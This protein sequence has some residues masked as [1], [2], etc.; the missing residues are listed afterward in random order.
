MKHISV[1][2]AALLLTATVY[3][4]PTR[5][6]IGKA[7][8]QNIITVEAVATGNSYMQQGLELTIKNNGSLTFILEMNA[9]TIFKAEQ[10]G[11]Q[12]LML[13]GE[14]TL[15]IR[16]LQE[17]EVIK[18]QTFCANSELGAPQEGLK[19]TYSRM[20][21]DTLIK[22]LGFI[23]QR[24]MYNRLGQ[25]AVWVFTNGHDLNTV[26][27][28]TNDFTSKQLLEFIT[29]HTERKMPGYF[30]EHKINTEAGQSVFEPKALKIYAQFEEKIKK[31]TT[32]TLGVYNEAGE[33]IQ[34]VFENRRFGK[35]GHRFKVEFEAEGVAPGKYY[36][37]LSDEEGVLQETMVEVK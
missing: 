14:E 10:D 36:I 28:G 31:T 23:H 22:V 26:Y 7:I 18:V 15:Y 2:L 1:F 27:D 19:Y 9:G 4:A 3:A 8:E 35:N 33:M 32:L 34:P 17:K 30:A 13:A 29:L 12:P 37:R 5:L 25:S 11:Y 20:A 16:P 24:R 6:A 21:G